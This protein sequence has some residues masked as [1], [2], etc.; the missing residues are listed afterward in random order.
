MGGNTARVD[1]GLEI[2]PVNKGLPKSVRSIKVNTRMGLC[3]Q[4]IYL[5]AIS[6]SSRPQISNFC[7][8]IYI[9]SFGQKSDAAFRFY[10]RLEPVDKLVV[11]GLIASC[12]VLLTQETGC[13]I[14]I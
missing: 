9:A 8:K 6:K 10:L 2:V 1:F 12:M 7:A 13:I 5:Q 11:S 3:S 4:D 14:P